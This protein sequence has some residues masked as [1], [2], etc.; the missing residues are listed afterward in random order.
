MSIKTSLNIKSILGSVVVLITIASAVI[1]ADH[2]LAKSYELIATNLRLDYKINKDIK[3]DVSNEIYAIE[4]RYGL[5]VSKMP[6]LIRNRYL[7]LKDDLKE[8]IKIM[9]EIR[10]NQMKKGG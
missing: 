2:Y 9:D 8:I 10:K 6:E 4:K 1:A 3:R 5:D 7:E